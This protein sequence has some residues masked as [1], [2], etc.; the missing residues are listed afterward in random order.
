MKRKA[1]WIAAVMGL[2]TPGRPLPLFPVMGAALA[3]YLALALLLL[4]AIGCETTSARQRFVTGCST[5]G[6]AMAEVIVAR[7][8]GLITVETFRTIDDQYD[9][10]VATCAFLPATDE[11]AVL[12]LDRLNAFLVAAGGATG[13]NYGTY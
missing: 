10:A 9:A 11:A 13:R 3:I 1:S 7:R 12:A 4:L 2:E 5:V 6:E 8:A